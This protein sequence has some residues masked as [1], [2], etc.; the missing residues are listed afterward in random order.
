M[1]SRLLAAAVVA[2]A[3]ALMFLL[4][5]GRQ[6]GSATVTGTAHQHVAVTGRQ[7]SSALPAIALALLALAVAVV[8]A[9]GIV[10]RLAAAVGLLVAIAGAGTALRA[11][12]DVTHALRARA[13]G[14]DVRTLATHTSGWWLLAASGALASAVAFGAIAVAGGRWQGMGARYDAPTAATRPKD[15]AASA[16]EALDRGDDPTD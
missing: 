14:V 12:G 7:V 10:R 5:A 3:G 4:A 13:F 1:K 15:P 8:A 2:A 9:S 16:W 6:W 11:A